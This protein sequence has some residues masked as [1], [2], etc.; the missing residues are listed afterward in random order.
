MSLIVQ[1]LVLLIVF[2]VVNYG[3]LVFPYKFLMKNFGWTGV[4]GYYGLL[5]LLGGLLMLY[6]FDLL[7]Y[8][9]I[10]DPEEKKFS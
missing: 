4:L 10:A 8:V 2:A 7:L 5:T 3:L 6:G 1:D 9:M